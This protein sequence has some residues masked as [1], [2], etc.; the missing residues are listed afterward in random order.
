M[1]KIVARFYVSS[2]EKKAGDT[3]T[4]H[5]QASVSKENARW[6]QY[7]PNG[8][9]TMDLTRKASGARAAFEQLVGKDALVTFDFDAPPPEQPEY[10][11]QGEPDELG[12]VS[13]EE[14]I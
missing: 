1:P 3:A 9:I 10:R 2:Y 11:S 8:Q 6:S 13:D 14:T 7:T 12:Y 5:L 4:V